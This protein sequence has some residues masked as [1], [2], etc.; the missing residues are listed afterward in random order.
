VPAKYRP[1]YPS[2]MGLGLAFV[3]PFW[4]TFSMFIGAL[5][6][7]ALTKRAPKWSEDYVIPIASGV[8]AGESLMGVGLNLA[9]IN[10]S[11]IIGSLQ[12]AGA[13]TPTPDVLQA[14]PEAL[15]AV[16]D[17]LQASPTPVP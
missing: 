4:N 9:T 1:Y 11:E 3:I 6:V 14:T 12:G 13:A 8:I 10:P 7:W 15:Q 16:G 2:A 17:A 5:I